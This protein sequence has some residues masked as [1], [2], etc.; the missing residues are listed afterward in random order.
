MLSYKTVTSYIYHFI[1]V[2]MKTKLSILIFTCFF[3]LKTN[4]SNYYWIGGTGN[5]DDLS[6]WATT[7]G[8]TTIYTQIPTAL[9][10][11]FFDANSFNGPGQKVIL[12]PLTIFVHTMNWTGVTNNPAMSGPASNLLKVY[13]SL[14]FSPSMNMSF[15]GIIDFESTTPGQIITTA[16]KVIN[17]S[18]QFNGIGGEWTLQDDLTANGALILDAGTLNSNNY[19]VTIRLFDSSPVTST[20]R[21]L[22]MGASVFNITTSVGIGWSIN[23][24][25][26][27][28]INAGTSTINMPSGYFTGGNFNYYDLNITNPASNAVATIGAANFHDIVFASN[29]ILNQGDYHNVTFYGDGTLY[30]GNF[31]DLNFAPGHGYTFLNNSTTTINGTFN[32]T[33][34]CNALIDIRSNVVTTQATISKASGTVNVSYA[35]IKDMNATGGATFNAANSGDLGNNTGWNFTAAGAQNL[36]WIGNG[37]NWSDGNHWSHTSGGVPSGCSPTPADNVFFDGNSFSIVAQT[38]TIDPLIAYCRNMDWSAVTNNPALVGLNTK[39]LKIF[40]SVTLGTDMHIGFSGQVNLE[41]INPGQTIT[42]AGQSFNSQVN[43]NG[44]G[45]EWTLQDVFTINGP[46]VLNA[47][48]F[49]SNNM[50]VNIGSFLSSSA[51]MR[52]LNMGSSVFNC[53]GWTA[54]SYPLTINCGT[55]VI[56][57]L[58]GGM[59]GGNHT[60]YDVNFTSSPGG[61]SN[62]NQFHD[63]VFVDRANIDGSNTFHSA[64]FYGNGSMLTNNTFDELTFTGGHNYEIRSIYINNTFNANGNCGAYLDIASQTP[65]IQAIIVK[66]SGIVNTSYLIL[67]DIVATGGA[68][69]NA[70]N[71]TDLGN[72]S[73]WNITAAIGQDLYWIGNGGNWSDGNHWSHTSGGVPS[74]CSPTPLDNIFFDANSFSVTGQTVTMDPVT[75]Y[76]RNMNWTGVTNNPALNTSIGFNQLKIYGSLTFSQNMTTPFYGLVYFEAV[77]PGQTITMAG[78]SFSSLVF[79]EGINGEWTFQ[80]TFTAQGTLVLNHGTLNTNGQTVNIRGFQ[81]TSSNYRALNLGASVINITNIGSNPQPWNIL[82]DYPNNMYVNSGTSV[83][84]VP[85]AEFNGGINKTYYDV[86][87][88]NTTAQWGSIGGNGNHFHNVVFKTQSGIVNTY[89]NNPV[90]CNAATFLGDG[91]IRG[92]NSFN[93]LNFTA[94]HAYTLQAGTTQTVNDHWRIQGSCTSY[95]VLQTDQAG[96]FA[97]VTKS[98]GD[99]PGY[100]IHI[101]DIHCIGGAN[102]IAYNSVD[103]GGNTGWNFSILP[104]LNN[105]NNII[106]PVVICQG[107]SSAVVYHI[108]PVT[109]AISYEWTVPAGA[110][111][112]SGQG[113]TTIVVDFGTATSGD[114]IVQSFNGCNYGSISSALS[115]TVANT[116][117]PAVDISADNNGPV[118]PGTAIT[119]TATA[120]GTGTGTVNYDFHVNGI[121]AQ[122]GSS[123]IFTTTSLSNIDEV[124]C[125]ITVGASSCFTAGTAISDTIVMNV[126]TDPVPNPQ[127]N[128]TANP[129]GVICTGAPVTFTA[130]VTGSGNSSIN[131]LFKING[132][133]VQNSNLSIYTSSSLSNNDIIT[134]EITLSATTCY[135]GATVISNAITANVNS[136]PAPDPHVTLSASESGQVCL[137]APVTFTAN[138]TGTGSGIINYDFLINGISVQNSNANTFTTNTLLNNDQVNCIVT[139]NATA[140]FNAASVV[141][142]IITMNVNTETAPN[143]QVSI[144]AAPEGKICAGLP[145]TFTASVT[146][147][148]NNSIEYDFKV[149]GNSIQLGNASTFT[150]STLRND[151]VITCT[152][153]VS[154]GACYAATTAS[155]NLIVMDGKNCNDCKPQIPNAITPNGDGFNDKWIISNRDCFRQVSVYVYNRY[156][157][158]VYQSNNYQNDWMG[159]F[160]SKALPDATYYYIIK[161]LT[162]DQREQVYKGNITLLR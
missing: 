135:A 95:I 4:A 3:F 100:N 19:T 107:A 116:L 57:F 48:T 138:A 106:G 143:P 32:A 91:N 115:I 1:S 45:G 147:A 144:T 53:R 75:A 30:G 70:A 66:S 26:L 151:D 157:S 81:S 139:V 46:L 34:N 134:C 12:N 141:S 63:V 113:D 54:G 131:Y 16:G 114:I 23:G 44:I 90:V 56:N 28:T 142:D 80:D 96:S 42:M 5:W 8:G 15:S 13:G 160:K 78:K 128:L 84:N 129:S 7:S 6:H 62:N 68:T 118:C 120:S 64:I 17:N 152:I 33:G 101:K 24:A 58:S 104:P 145:I 22:N 161:A 36:Y 119:F 109:G 11:V 124:S 133:G 156:G 55:S 149:N 162:T 99:V 39:T 79:F 27:M 76:C 52:T 83:I 103:L 82:N 153:S 121:S 110:T 29:G 50:T 94:G 123:N 117:N 49:T 60:Y 93:D 97:S 154:G 159:T 65:G 47:G 89:V 41:A 112:I 127:T 98:A 43:V 88:T 21:A 77:T 37:G 105:P 92:N 74:G 155:S 102:F 38:V 72:N 69:F 108:P 25:N 73:G 20:P 158:L 136:D 35:I 14:I 140:C 130:S 71:T 2:R 132:I 10:D 87:F 40:G 137:H 85:N 125:I 18:I 122:S 9:D 51:T 59:F 31:N 67:K 86:N 148:G 126:N 150:I 61:I 146:D 111:I